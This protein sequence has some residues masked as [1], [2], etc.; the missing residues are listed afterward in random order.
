MVAW[1]NVQLS[2]NGY[3]GKIV[4]FFHNILEKKGSPVIYVTGLEI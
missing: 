2:H 3:Y 4:G 1:S